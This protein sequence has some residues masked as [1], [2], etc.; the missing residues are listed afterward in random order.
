MVSPGH[1]ESTTNAQGYKYSKI[2]NIS[3]TKF[4]NLNVQVLVAA[5]SCLCAIYWSHVLSG[6]WRCSWSSSDRRCSNYIWVINNL[7][8]DWSAACIRELT[9]SPFACIPVHRPSLSNPRSRRIP[10]TGVTMRVC[11]VLFLYSQS[12]PS[13][14]TGYYY[15]RRI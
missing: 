1:T 9:A 15:A 12:L 13:K 11:I 4:Q 3:R 5:C 6:E 14:L 2:S 10:R 7:I 8:A